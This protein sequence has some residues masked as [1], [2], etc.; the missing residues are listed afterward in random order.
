MKANPLNG[1]TFS[2]IVYIDFIF[3]YIYN[4]FEVRK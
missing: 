4:T 2:R 1:I 3:V